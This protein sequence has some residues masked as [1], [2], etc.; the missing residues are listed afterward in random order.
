M[1]LVRVP[2]HMV[3]RFIHINPWAMTFAYFSDLLT[4]SPLNTGHEEELQPGQNGILSRPSLQRQNTRQ[5]DR[6]ITTEL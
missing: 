3:T 1:V 5:E 4:T 6:E 2:G